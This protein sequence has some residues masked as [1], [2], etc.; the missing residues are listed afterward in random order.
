MGHPKAR[1]PNGS[2]AFLNTPPGARP[3]PSV[4][5]LLRESLARRAFFL[6]GSPGYRGVSTPGQVGGLQRNQHVLPASFRFNRYPH[7]ECFDVNSTTDNVNSNDRG[8]E[9]GRKTAMTT[10]D[11]SALGLEG[12]EVWI[13]KGS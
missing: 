12:L 1:P 13:S 2:S 8:P 3:T 10:T 11:G 4:Q 5:W 9:K 6:R 7:D